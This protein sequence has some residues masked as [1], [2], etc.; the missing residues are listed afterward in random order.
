MLDPIV[1]DFTGEPANRGSQ[2]PKVHPLQFVATAS[3]YKFFPVCSERINRG[4]YQY[5]RRDY[6]RDSPHGGLICG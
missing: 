5:S 1:N 6:G 4:D 2:L 3:A